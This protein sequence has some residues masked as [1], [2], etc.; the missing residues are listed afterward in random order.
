MSRTAEQWDAAYAE[1]EADGQTLWTAGPNATVAAVLADR[2]PGSAV[3]VAAGEGRH[4]LWLAEQG[5]Q[6]TAVDFSAVGLDRAARTAAARGLDLTTACADVTTWQ[7]DGPVDLVLC[8]YLHLPSV[9]TRRLL[10]RMGRWVAPGGWL[11]TLGHD[12]A[13]LEQGVGG[14]QDDD[15]LW[16]EPGLRSA[17]EGAGLEVVRAEQVRR[18]VDGEPRPALDVLQIAQRAG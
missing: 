15:V 8:A 6:V 17:A 16:D 5:W 14:P 4:A 3:D 7:P 18:P 10:D 2:A 13:N 9:P 11:V 1:R 12:R